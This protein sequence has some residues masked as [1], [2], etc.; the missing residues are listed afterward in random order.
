LSNHKIDQNYIDFKRDNENRVG[1]IFQKNLE[2]VDTRIVSHKNRK[3]ILSAIVVERKVTR[4]QIVLSGRKFPAKTGTFAEFRLAHRKIIMIA[5][6]IKSLRL[7]DVER[8]DGVVSREKLGSV[9]SLV[10]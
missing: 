7:L 6:T 2:M 1:T 3:T 5:I 8:R 4:H 9:S 10:T